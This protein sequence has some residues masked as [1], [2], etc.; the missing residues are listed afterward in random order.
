MAKKRV[1]AGTS[2]PR[3][4]E[5]RAD[6]VEA[7]ISNGGN[8]TQAAIKAGY[9][10]K[11]ADVRAAELLRDCRVKD[12][13]AARAKKVAEITGLDTE[14][15]AREIARLAYSDLRKFYRADG[16]L[17][18]IPELDDDSAACVA[19]VEVD[20]IGIEGVVIGHT[21]KI[22]VWDKNA[23]LEKAAKIHG[24]Y[25]EDNKQR[26]A[27]VYVPIAFGASD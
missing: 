11:G 17:I 19:M 7:Y 1:K 2:K 20:E 23:A 21:K 5:R 12:V 22:K 13:I 10:K 14:R 9:S 4:A 8:G 25:K 16:S 3:A 26:G 6:F 15:T 27:C 18:P 24:L